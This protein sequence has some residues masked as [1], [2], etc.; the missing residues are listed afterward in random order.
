LT[1]CTIA[2]NTATGNTAG[3]SGGGI[4]GPASLANT[5]V[6]DNTAD[7][8]PDVSG[9]FTS[10][11][12]NLIGKTDVS[13]GWLISDLTGTAAVPL[14]A[15]L[16]PLQNNGGPTKTM[17]LLAGSPALNTGD[18]T[19]APATDQRGVTRGA[20]VNIGAYQATASVLVLTG[21]PESAAAGAALDFTLTAE[22]MFGQTAFGYTGTVTFT[23][24][25]DLAALPDDYVFTVTDGG[26]HTFV[27]GVT[28]YQT[29]VQTLTASDARD[30]SLSVSFDLTVL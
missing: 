18:A 27:G 25:D 29:G 7:G 10:R 3:G 22:D 20:T 19:L 14:D 11:G 2:G 8:G 21:L 28:F 16:G 6:A 26:T 30:A 24:T 17:A 12:H 13:T 4:G 1:N 5:V 23:S 9:A 15:R